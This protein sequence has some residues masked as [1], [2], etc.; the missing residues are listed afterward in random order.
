MADPPERRERYRRSELTLTSVGFWAITPPRGKSSLLGTGELVI[1]SFKSSSSALSAEL[2][3]YLSNNSH[4][5]T[6][7][8]GYIEI[9]FATTDVHFR[10]TADETNRSNSRD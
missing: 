5:Y 3:Q 1:L 2:A 9:D 4:S 10:W 6:L 7:F 8:A